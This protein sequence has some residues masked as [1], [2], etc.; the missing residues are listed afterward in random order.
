MRLAVGDLVVYAPHGI[1]R[2]VA[3]EKQG[4]PHAEQE[5]VVLELAN[6]LTVTL[7]M[8]RAQQQLRPAASEADMRR[9][10]ETLREDIAMSGDPWLARRRETEAK[11]AAGDAVG[12]A[13]IVRDGVRR[14]RMLAEKGGGKAGRSQLSMGELALLVKARQLLSGEIALIRGFELGEAEAWI[15][16]QIAPTS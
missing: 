14:E 11:L 12:L 16:E 6:G 13:E 9:V 8:A 3:R 4:G 5:I 7:S 10:Q 15:D 2:V 1:G